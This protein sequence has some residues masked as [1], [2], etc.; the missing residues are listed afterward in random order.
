RQARVGELS[1][2]KGVAFA[3][4]ARLGVYAALLAREGMTGPAPIF[5]GQMGFEKE[6]GVSLGDVASAFDKKK[7]AMPGKGPASMILKTSISYWPAQYHS[8]GAIA[9]AMFLRKAIVDP[10]KFP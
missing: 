4:A 9:R 1:H 6:L 7:E 5:E 10:A 2:W 8:T 3:N